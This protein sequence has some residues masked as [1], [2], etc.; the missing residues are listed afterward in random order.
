MST[1]V[2]FR[3]FA[4]AVMAGDRTRA[5]AVLQT[6][7]GVTPDVA[8]RATATFVDRMKDPAFVAKAMGLR[9]AV[10]SGTDAEVRSLLGEC[11]GLADEPLATAVSSLRARYPG[12]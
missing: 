10:T 11:F 4:G 12:P 5:A 7:L 8:E 9:T 2:T 1:D 6:L 3:D